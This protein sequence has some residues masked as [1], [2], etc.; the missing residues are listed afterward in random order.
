MAGRLAGTIDGRPFALVATGDTATLRLSS[1]FTAW[2]LGRHAS[3][4]RRRLGPLCDRAGIRVRVKTPW[5]PAFLLL[6]SR[7]GVLEPR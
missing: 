3:G 5:L 1:V 6:P 2:R 7:G 4:L